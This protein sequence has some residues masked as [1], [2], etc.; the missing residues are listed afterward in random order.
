[1]ISLESSEGREAVTLAR[2]PAEPYYGVYDHAHRV[3]YDHAVG[4]TTYRDADGYV[5]DE[6]GFR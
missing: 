6:R 3:P 4:G 1:M 5:F 2:E